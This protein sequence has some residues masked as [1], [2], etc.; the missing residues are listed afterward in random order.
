[1]SDGNAILR[2]PPYCGDV[3]AGLAV[4]TGA[5]VNAEVV[6]GAFVVVGCVV[7][8]AGAHDARSA[9][10]VI[11]SADPVSIRLFFMKKLNPLFLSPICSLPRTYITSLA[12]CAKIRSMLTLYHAKG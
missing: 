5:V 9:I 8:A 7:V 6:T 12:S 1:M 4:V 11:R 10:V 3:S 2:T